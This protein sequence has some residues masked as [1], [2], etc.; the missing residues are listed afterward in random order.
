[1]NEILEKYRQLSEIPSDINEHL[2]TLKKYTEECETIVEMGVRSIISTWAFLAGNPKKLT[3]LDLYN[4]TKFGGNLQEVYD[5]VNL[6]DID[7]SFVEY[8]SLN[9]EL[10][11]CDLLFI[12]TWHCYLQ[13]KKELTR[14]HSKVNKYIILHDTVS[15]ANVDEK[16]ADEM[17]VLNTIETNLPKGLWSAVEEFLYEN[18]NWIV[19][20]KKPNNNGLTVLKRIDTL[21]TKTIKE[22]KKVALISTFCDNQEKLDVLEKNIKIV[23]SH[24]IDVIVISPFTLPEQINKLCDYVFIT[25]D[26]P[27]LEWPVRGM[28]AWRKLNVNGVIHEIARAYSDYG[29]AGLTQIKQ[30]SDIALTMDYNQFYHMIYD[31][32][33]DENVIAGF[34][35][36]R[37]CSVYP[38]KRGDNIWAV[39]LH[40][41]IFNRTSLEKFIKYITLENYLNL[42][43]GEAFAWLHS[44][45]DKVGYTIEKIPVEDE[46]YYYNNYDFF[47]M[48]PIKD[49][50]F[51]IENNGEKLANIKLYFY[52]HEGEKIIDVKVGDI[53]TKHIVKQFDFIDLGFDKLNYQTVIVTFDSIDY[54]ISDII[55]GIK[56][57]VL[58]IG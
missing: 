3:S 51:F 13:L 17:G 34:N 27:I 22:Q 11:P 19:W 48:S 12:D 16:S 14:H 2:V 30:L 26:N 53:K 38:S 49:F 10:E 7:F 46:I 45:K 32:K 40:Y 33:I 37:T 50:K 6:T 9:Y 18:K 47:N 1:M 24:N 29:F 23:K 28:Y 21:P 31:I 55:M 5:A 39:G 35:S 20:E 43:N 36:N 41:M 44:I 54:D 52:E 58:N 56:H 25:K 4:P 8:D 42:K 15:Y 57:N